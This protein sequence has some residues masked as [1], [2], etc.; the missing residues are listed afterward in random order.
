[1]RWHEF[2]DRGECRLLEFSGF[3]LPE[4]TA[5]LNRVGLIRELG[6]SAAD[7]SECTYFGLMTASPEESAEQARHALKTGGDEQAYTAI[8]GRVAPG[9]TETAIA[10]F[11]APSSI[12]GDCPLELIER[13]QAAL[14]TVASRAGGTGEQA[15]SFLQTLGDLLPQANVREGLFTYAGRIYRLRLERAEDSSAT[16]TFRERGLVPAS[17]SVVRVT[18]RTRPVSGGKESV[19]RLWIPT[20]ERRPLPLRI[21]YQPRND[22]RLLFAAV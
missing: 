12:S 8:R 6:R 7:V 14:S 11:S 9:A 20:G 21:E 19:F 22:L 3:S 10:H 4:R 15:G 2:E 18:G 1:V 17:A 13:A 16:A 5:G